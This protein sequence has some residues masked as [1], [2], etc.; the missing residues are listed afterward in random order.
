M[1]E[2]L[3]TSVGTRRCCHGTNAPWE[4]LHV[5]DECSWEKMWTMEIISHWRLVAWGRW[6]QEGSKL[7]R[8]RKW[9]RSS[10]FRQ[11]DSIHLELKSHTHRKPSSCSLTNLKFSVGYEFMVLQTVENEE[12]VFQKKRFYEKQMDPWPVLFSICRMFFIFYCKLLVNQYLCSSIIMSFRL[13][14]YMGFRNLEYLS[15]VSYGYIVFR[16]HMSISVP[17]C[18]KTQFCLNLVLLD[19][20]F[21]YC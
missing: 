5:V 8:E 10:R 20:P 19:Y 12:K 11:S 7:D 21:N 6:R 13:N 2:V 9:E 4:L 16:W 1:L 3:P 17:F 15:L 18:W 14:I